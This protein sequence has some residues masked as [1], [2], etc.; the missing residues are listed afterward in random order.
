MKLI[1]LDK[2]NIGKCLQVPI[3]S[4]D[5]VILLKSNS[6]LTEKNINHL[7]NVGIN[8]A[9]ISDETSDDLSLQETLESPVRLKCLKDLNR[10]FSSIKTI[11]VLN[12]KVIFSLSED[13]ISNLNISENAFLFNNIAKSDK[14]S[15]L[16]VHSL[17]VAILTAI[18]GMKKNYPMSKLIELVSVAL[19][20]DIGKVFE[21]NDTHCKLGYDIIKNSPN[22]S[23]MIYVSTLQHHE[24]E[25]GSGFPNKYKGDK[26]HEYA[27]IVGICNE[28]LNLISSK[29][30]TFLPNEAVETITA[31]A[32][33]KF[34]KEIYKHFLSSIYCYPNGLTVHLNNGLEGMVVMQNKN[35]PLRPVIGVCNGSE[36]KFINLLFELTLFIEK[37]VI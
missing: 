2:K 22:F 24:Y 37:I 19:L 27:K 25:D 36:T 7:K 8:T 23:T 28:Y 15:S 4:Y 1:T 6:L 11:K 30:K 31:M 13:L 32:S 17:D 18:V 33:S 34:D 10:I 5:G 35:Y 26:I 29:E 20:H 16:S 14:F 12:N 21:E 3:Y 9:Y